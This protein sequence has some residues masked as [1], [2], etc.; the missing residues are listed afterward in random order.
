MIGVGSLLGDADVWDDTPAPS[1]PLRRGLALAGVGLLAGL[2]VGW[3]V[4]PRPAPAAPVVSL[5]PV[6]AVDAQGSVLP[7]GGPLTEQAALAGAMVVAGPGRVDEVKPDGTG[8]RA[9]SS[10]FVPLAVLP[11]RGGRPTVA[12]G[13]SAVVTL[14]RNGTVDRLTPDGFWAGGVAGGQGQVL[15]CGR[16]PLPL[17]ERRAARAASRDE[18][19]AAPALLLPVK[20][21]KESEVALGCPVSWAA[22]APV[23]AGAG[24]PQVRYRRTTRGSSVLAGRVGGPLRTL[25]DRRGLESATGPGASVGAVAVSPDGKLVAVAAGAPGGRWALLLVPVG[26]DQVR[27]I[28]LVP[29]YEATWLTWIGRAADEPRLAMAA[30]DRRGDLGEAGLGSRGG[31]GYVLGWDQAS[32]VAATILAGPAMERADGFAFSPDGQFLAVSSAAG[33]TMLR[34]AD[35]SERESV[36]LTGT[37]LAWPGTTP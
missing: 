31:G 35:P 16:R 20:G 18:S 3:A 34:T 37:L 21:G 26:G 4:A 23:V 6:R 9:L 11:G 1:R 19:V 30:V 5:P 25:L 7:H 24:G 10:D 8:R 15:A 27:R 2:A 12:L 33:W 29:G 32:D 36:P 22:G 17:A 13:G 14:D 28:E